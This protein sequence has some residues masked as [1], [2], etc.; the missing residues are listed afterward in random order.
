M[1]RY[2]WGG[3]RGDPEVPGTMKW[4]YSVKAAI[5]I[6]CILPHILHMT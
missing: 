5:C 2:W 6:Y 3:F 4:E 1:G